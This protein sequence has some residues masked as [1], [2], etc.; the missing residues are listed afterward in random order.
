MLPWATD[1][2][3]AGLMRP[4][5]LLLHYGGL[6]CNLWHLFKIFHRKF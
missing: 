5:G 1:N 2:A 6:G 3:V 4:V